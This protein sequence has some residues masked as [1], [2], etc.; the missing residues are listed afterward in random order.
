MFKIVVFVPEPALEVVKAALFAAGAGKIGAYDQCC[1]QTPGVGQFRPLEGS[2][3][4]IGS[5]GVVEKVA[6]FRVELVCDDA[7]LERAISAMVAA[8][9]YEEPA[10]DV[11]RVND[12][13]GR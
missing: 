9:P 1:W 7:I 5:H 6:E 11:W 10:Y 8:H 2:D 12:W 3:P 4:S 13:Q